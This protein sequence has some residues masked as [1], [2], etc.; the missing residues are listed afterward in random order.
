MTLTDL[1]LLSL[2]PHVAPLVTWPVT[3]ACTAEQ[4]PLMVAVALPAPVAV[5]VT[6]SLG[7][8]DPT[9]AL[10]RPV[11]AT[12]HAMAPSEDVRPQGAP[13]RGR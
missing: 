10:V 13:A 7:A 11:V 2:M 1:A 5:T 9:Q 4:A 8:N 12:W 3:G 6:Y